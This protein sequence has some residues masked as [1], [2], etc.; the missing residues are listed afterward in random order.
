MSTLLPSK[1]TACAG[2]TVNIGFSYSP[3]TSIYWYVSQDQGSTWTLVTT[4]NLNPEILTFVCNKTQN[5]NYY[6][7]LVVTPTGSFYTNYCILT[8][9]YLD[10]I[11]Q[12]LGSCAANV[13]YTFSFVTDGNI[14]YLT[15]WQSTTDGVNWSP[16]KGATGT[17]YFV[18]S[19]PSNVYYRAQ[20][21]GSCFALSTNPNGYQ[22]FYNHDYKA[23][24]NDNMF[25]ITNTSVPAGNPPTGPWTF[26][27]G[28]GWQCVSD[29]S[30]ASTTSFLKFK[31]YTVIIPGVYEVTFIHYYDFT[32]TANGGN[33]Q[34]SVNG[35]P[36][37]V[38]PAS[39]FTQGGYSIDFCPGVGGGPSWYA[40]GQYTAKAVLGTFKTGDVIS[41]GFLAGWVNGS[42][43]D[44]E[45]QHLM[46]SLSFCA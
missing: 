6:R 24:G 3:Y 2:Q 38:V 13:G 34:L 33:L 10:I 26:K 4:I 42:L 12:P 40:M 25:T 14:P 30:G 17:S 46:I 21:K 8:V 41:V 7:A 15:T 43:F 28:V 31:P 44:W 5:G 36:Y 19:L 35:A 45:L 27:T 29:M 32:D 9:Q 11:T 39:N 18:A 23:S 16:I 1:V 37:S 20:I 22:V